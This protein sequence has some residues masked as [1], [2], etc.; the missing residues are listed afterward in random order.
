MD[1][2][3]AG[4]LGA[5]AAYRTWL[6]RE[7]SATVPTA[8]DEIPAGRANGQPDQGRGSDGIRPARR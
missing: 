1:S 2:D 5:N 3:E 7:T 6:V 4:M 8:P